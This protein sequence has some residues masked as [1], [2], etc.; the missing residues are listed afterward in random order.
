V[1]LGSLLA[2]AYLF[3]PTAALSVVAC[4]AVLAAGPRPGA[5]L[6]ST[7]AG[8]ALWLMPFVAWSMATRGT[9]VPPYY[10]AGRL[11]LAG[12]GTG[13]MGDLVSP[14]RG[15]LIY[16]PWLPWLAWAA[17]RARRRLVAPRLVLAA[18]AVTLAHLA[19]VGS[20]PQ[21]YGG[22][23]FGA[24]MTTELMPWWFVVAVGVAP[25]IHGFGRRSASTWLAGGLVVLAI[26]LNGIGAA[27]E[28]SWRWNSRHG[29]IDAHPERLWSVRDAQF[30][31]P[32]RDQPDDRP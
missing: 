29:G 1:V 28:A 15:T 25:A 12:L 7:M 10:A 20:F 18:A 17:W 31:A 26:V 16:V 30:L 4:V 21:W 14:S 8:L 13:L 19:M 27:S 24:R 5:L 11:S 2:W 32:V 22:H 23:C 6:G 9:L 3:R